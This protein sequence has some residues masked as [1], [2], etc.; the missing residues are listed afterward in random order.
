VAV[1]QAPELGTPPTTSEQPFVSPQPAIEPQ[2]AIASQQGLATVGWEEGRKGVGK[3][4]LVFGE[5]VDVGGT[6]NIQFINFSKTDR[7]AFKL[8]IQSR[9]FEKFPASLSDAYLG[10]KVVADGF[11][12]LYNGNPQIVL[13]RPEQIQVVDTFP[14]VFLPAEGSVAVGDEIRI[15]TCNMLNLFD[16]V[17]DPYTNDEGTPEKPRVELETLAQRLRGLNADVI[18]MQEVESRGY[19]QRF[20]DIFLADMGYRYVVHFEGNDMRGIDVCLV[21]RVPVARVISH[22]HL[23]FPAEP[24]RTGEEHFQRDLLCVELTPEKGDSFEVWVVHLKSKGG[25]SQESEP[26]RM[27]EAKAIRRIA[28]ARL[29]ENPDLPFVICGDFNDTWDS[30]SLRTIVGTGSGVLRAFFDEKPEAERITYN[31][32]PHRSMIDFL[33]CSPAMAQRYVAGSFEL[34]DGSP[35][36]TGSDHNPVMCRFKAFRQPSESTAEIGTAE[37]T[38]ARGQDQPQLDPPSTLRTAT[39]ETIRDASTEAPSDESI[40]AEGSNPPFPMMRTKTSRLLITGL[41]I[42]ALGGLYMRLLNR[43]SPSRKENLR[44]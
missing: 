3:R 7:N 4:A 32:E 24:P 17:D 39:R 1:G 12:T 29:S 16:A 5:V 42:G 19:L 41:L 11:V 30:P 40:S 9:N 33:L 26:I 21:S 10:K 13:T 25:E 36:T 28:D 15:A 44:R 8:V 18:A 23:T 38:V 31:L 2:P 43:K 20:L 34:E 22:R 27:A 35:D 6:P 14:E 37:S